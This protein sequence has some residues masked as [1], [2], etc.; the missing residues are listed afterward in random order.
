[1][2]IECNPQSHKYHGYIRVKISLHVFIIFSVNVS[3]AGPCHM[4]DAEP[5]FPT[6]LGSF[7][8]ELSKTRLPRIF[9]FLVVLVTFHKHGM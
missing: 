3:A 9:S 4:H 5:G 8:K 7:Y 2:M 1:M 6:Q